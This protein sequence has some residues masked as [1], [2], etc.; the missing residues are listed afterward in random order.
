[1]DNSRN[2]NPCVVASYVMGVCSSGQYFVP[3]LQPGSTHY[4]IQNTP[5]ACECNTVAYCL[6][7]A[8]A[9]CQNASS[10]KYGF[11]AV[12][13]NLILFVHEIHSSC[14]IV[15]LLGLSIARRPMLGTRLASP[16]ALQ[17]RNGLIKMLFRV[18]ISM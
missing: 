7:S 11:F 13:L 14:I 17:Y 5:T 10:I 12:Y 15:G 18:M 16:M 1:M 9:I 4:I 6:I 2:Q 8:C 3:V